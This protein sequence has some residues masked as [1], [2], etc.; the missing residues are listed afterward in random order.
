LDGANAKENRSTTVEVIAPSADLR[1]KLAVEIAREQTLLLVAKYGYAGYVLATQFSPK[2]VIL[3][4]NRT[5]EFNTLRLQIDLRNL[6]QDRILP[7]TIVTTAEH[8]PN[9]LAQFKDDAG[10]RTKVFVNLS[11][12]VRRPTTTT[13]STSC[14]R[15]RRKIRKLRRWRLLPI[16]AAMRAS[17]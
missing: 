17:K 10:W 2:D 15:S 3:L 13:F 14:K 11:V 5:D 4:D 8:V 9:V 7:L 6:C 12:S 16:P 1:E